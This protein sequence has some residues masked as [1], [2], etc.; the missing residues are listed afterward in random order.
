MARLLSLPIII[1]AFLFFS[2]LELGAAES[3]YQCSVRQGFNFEKDSQDLVGHINYMKIGETE[4][5]SDLSVTDPENITGD[6]V[7]VFGIAEN[8]Y[9]N[10]GY[11][12][13][14]LFNSNVSTENKNSIATLVHT[15]LVNTEV[16]IEFTVYSYDPK[17][18][19]YYKAFHS[20][21]VRLKGLIHK[22]GGDMD[23]SIDMDQSMEVVSPKN[24]FFV[25]GVMPHEYVQEVHLG[26][27]TYDK[28]IKSWGIAVAE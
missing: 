14:I 21:G 12:N 15:D 28:F 27:S 1:T 17:Q 22:S 7:K 8:V 20:N 6:K 2:C 11:T 13:P 26:V 25:I 18:K 23:M 10:G 19:R 3:F 16:E 5:K 24:Y 4:L 9:W